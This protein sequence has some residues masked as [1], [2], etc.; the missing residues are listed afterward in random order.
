MKLS[1]LI[2]MYNVERYIKKC[3]TSL[4]NQGIDILDYEIIVV[5][6][7]STDNSLE[8]AKTLSQK[9]TNIVVYSQENKGTVFTR[10]RMLKLAKGEYI[11]F[12]DADDYVASNALNV[13]LNF[14]TS[15]QL[16]LVGFDTLVTKRR[17]KNK[18]DKSFVTNMLP[19]IVIGTEYLKDNKNLRIEIWWYFV[20]KDFLEKYNIHFDRIDYDGDVVFTLKLFLKAKRVAYFP[21][22]IYRYFQSPKSTIRGGNS[23]SKKRII[24]YFIALIIDFSNLINIVE[25]K[26]IPHKDTI[27]G[28]FKFRRDVFVFFTIT[29]MIKANLNIKEV[30]R[31]LVAIETV[32][33]YPM[34]DFNSEEFSR[35]RY[36]ILK[37]LLNNEFILFFILKTYYFI[38][39]KILRRK[40]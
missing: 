24:D 10:N 40:F 4:L 38:P 14:A 29:K 17:E 7:G 30:K 20:R 12:V 28:N 13:I 11:Y 21:F 9:H 27:L 32:N 37:S 6:D 1:V 39:K 5:N 35:I 22:K 34:K 3:L 25:E 16:D 19:E 36:K 23:K 15:N 33:G 26:E 18:L 31:N 2:P 8:I